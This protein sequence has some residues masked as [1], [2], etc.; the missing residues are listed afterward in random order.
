M[1]YAIRLRSPSL[2]KDSSPC[3]KL[4]PGAFI[5]WTHSK[6]AAAAHDDAAGVHDSAATVRSAEEDMPPMPIQQQQHSSTSCSSLSL[7]PCQVIAVHKEAG[8]DPYFT[9]Q[10]RG[11]GQGGREVQIDWHK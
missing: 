10:C 6:H 11:E 9:V 7:V 2:S 5:K 1:H 3:E 4:A 8:A